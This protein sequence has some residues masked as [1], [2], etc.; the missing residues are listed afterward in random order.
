MISY[1]YLS[2]ENS[3]ITKKFDTCLKGVEEQ[4]EN[5]IK[6]SKNRVS[7]GIKKCWVDFLVENLTFKELRDNIWLFFL[8]GHETTAQCHLE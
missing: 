7:N 3:F 5:I 1:D 6:E 2:L 4:I 8:A